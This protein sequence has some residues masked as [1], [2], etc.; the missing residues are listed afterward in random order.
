MPCHS[1]RRIPR[2][3]CHTTAFGVDGSTMA[4]YALAV[5]DHAHLS[6]TGSR[7]QKLRCTNRRLSRILPKEP[8]TVIVKAGLALIVRGTLLVHSGAAH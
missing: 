3:T 8:L 1:D 5:S 4:T 7:H 6:P 2:L